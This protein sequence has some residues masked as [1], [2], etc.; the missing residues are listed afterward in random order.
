MK[1]REFIKTTLM[2]SAGAALYGAFGGR[3]FAFN[4]SSGLGLTLFAQPLRGVGPG[5]IPVASPDAFPAPVTGV[6]HYSVAITQYA[7]TLHKN[8]GP[9]TLWGY[10]PAVALGEGPYPT[11]H[12][13]GVIIGHKG[14]PVQI[15]F[16]NNLPATHI[17]PVDASPFFDDVVAHG[18]NRAST[19]LHG[20]FVPWISDG[21]AM[22]WFSP[23]SYG[24]STPFATYQALNPN[25]AMGQAELY[26]PNEQ[27]ALASAV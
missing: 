1:R 5:G 11:R 9:T 16:T 18:V 8:L 24:P 25:L 20:G 21:G 22:S 13:G 15:T 14:V 17:L 26:Y 27:S 2:A 3:V 4:S 12:L 19:H 23:T 6:T 7:D 10:S